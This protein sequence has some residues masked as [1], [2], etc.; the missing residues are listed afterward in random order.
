MHQ[1]WKHIHYGT[2]AFLELKNQVVDTVLS[3]PVIFQALNFTDI[4]SQFLEI[5]Y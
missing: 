5:L 1:F 2:S 4:K 3:A